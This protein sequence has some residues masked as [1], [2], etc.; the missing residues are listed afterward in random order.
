M[1]GRYAAG[2]RCSSGAGHEG[3]K[4]HILQKIGGLIVGLTIVEKEIFIP[5]GSRANRHHDI[6]KVS[7]I[8]ELVLQRWLRIM[9]E[10]EGGLINEIRLFYFDR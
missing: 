4:V 10:S 2:R 3:I 1:L 9:T 6:S 5:G 7:S 8:G